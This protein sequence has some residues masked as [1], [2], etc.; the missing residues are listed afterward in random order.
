M[1][2]G[3]YWGGGLCVVVNKLCGAQ[4]KTFQGTSYNIINLKYDAII[5][6]WRSGVQQYITLCWR[7]L[8]RSWRE[9]TPC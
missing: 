5:V 4:S 3:I 7:A 9:E 1:G 8:H 2:G 6:K